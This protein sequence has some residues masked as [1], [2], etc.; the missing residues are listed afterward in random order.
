MKKRDEANI[1]EAVRI[2]AAEMGITPEEVRASFE[3]VESDPELAEWRAEMTRVLF[4]TLPAE[5][6]KRRTLMR[7]R[8]H[9]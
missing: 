5:L 3:K 2:V 7:R 8:R 4:S 6:R 1:E 9:S